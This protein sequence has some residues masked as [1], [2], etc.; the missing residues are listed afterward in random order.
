M[1]IAERIIPAPRTCFVLS[2]VLFLV[3]FATSTT[4]FVFRK[5]MDDH[6]TIMIDQNGDPMYEIDQWASFWNG[7]PANISWLFA[8][9]L[10]ILGIILWIRSKFTAWQSGRRQP[11]QLAQQVGTSNGG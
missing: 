7:W 6:G 11:K 2:L 10:L 3:A 5:R 1:S 9:F 8:Q 4:T